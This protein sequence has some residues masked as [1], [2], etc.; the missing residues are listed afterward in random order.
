MTTATAL[1]R[2]PSPSPPQTGARGEKRVVVLETRVVAGSGGGPDKTI[3]NTPRFLTASGYHTVCAYMH[4]PTDPGFDQLREK[5]AQWGAPLLSVADRGATDL[6]VIPRM[7]NVCRREKVAVWH[8]HDYKSNALGLLLARF[9]KM[10]LITTV[11]GWVQHTSR[12]PLYYWV[13][14]VCLPRYERVICV[15]EDLRQRCLESGVSPQR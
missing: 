8:G 5:A 2:T 6:G 10:R 15:S 13:D 11:H 4:P 9:W 1:P 3:L 14:R 7:L 12:T